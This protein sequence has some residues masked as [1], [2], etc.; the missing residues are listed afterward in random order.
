L[1]NKRLPGS[2]IG[3]KQW[4]LF[5]LGQT[6]LHLL[7]DSL[8]VYG[9]GWLEPFYQYRFS[10]NWLYVA[11]F[12]FSL[13]PV[14][15]FVALL[16]LNKKSL[17]RIKWV[18]FGLGMSVIYLVYCGYNKYTADKEITTAL[19]RQQVKYTDYFTT[20]TPFN[21]WLWYVV[22]ETDSGYYTGYHSV[23]DRDDFITLRY[24]KA[25]HHLLVPIENETETKQLVRFSKGF[26]TVRNFNDSLV[27]SDLRFGQIRGWNESDT[28][29]AF[30]YFLQHPEANALVVQR[31]RFAGWDK[32]AIEKLLK[33]IKGN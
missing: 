28:A 6:L 24:N 29:F 30:Y 31:G 17:V 25:N 22:A 11:D 9:V 27:F 19:Q 13:W 5:F 1:V 16:F 4:Y 2:D 15:A 26:Y 3:L 14:M 10:F 20:P 18:K 8:N 12:L 21:T 23:F 32:D 7:L 33:R